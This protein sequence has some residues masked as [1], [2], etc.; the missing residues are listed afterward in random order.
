MM[1][2]IP[3]QPESL[4]LLLE[5]LQPFGSENRPPSKESQRNLMASCLPSKMGSTC[6]AMPSHRMPSVSFTWQATWGKAHPEPGSLVSVSIHPPYSPITLPLWPHLRPT[7]VTR[8]FLEPRP[9]VSLH[10]AKRVPR[11]TQL[12]FMSLLLC[13]TSL[14]FRGAN[15]FTTG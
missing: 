8:I 14:N 6:N 13:S 1:H 7:S 15:T 9:V 2:L 10:S 12:D 11:S 5:V 4:P 3:L